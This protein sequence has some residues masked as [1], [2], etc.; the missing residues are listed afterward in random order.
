[1]CVCVCMQVKAGECLHHLFSA[2]ILGIIAAPFSHEF[3]TAILPLLRNEEITQPLRHTSDDEETIDMFI[4]KSTTLLYVGLY[5][6]Y[7][8]DS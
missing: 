6:F 3:A 1:M 5:S 2:K 7:F 8:T 4:C